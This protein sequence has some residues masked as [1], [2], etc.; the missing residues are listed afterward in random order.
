MSMAVA[1]R[2]LG[3]RRRQHHGRLFGIQRGAAFSAKVGGGP[4]LNQVTA[5]APYYFS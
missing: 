2:G 4:E 3:L 1:V 5:V